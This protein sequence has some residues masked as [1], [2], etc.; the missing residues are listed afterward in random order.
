[1]NCFFPSLIQ[2]LSFLADWALQGQASLPDIICVSC[3]KGG[4]GE[5]CGHIEE[6]G[7][8]RR[9]QPAEGV[10]QRMG[11][12]NALTPNKYITKCFIKY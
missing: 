2:F 11:P 8:A 6:G 4:Q 5:V 7:A 9:R 12:G 1:M 3:S 10:H